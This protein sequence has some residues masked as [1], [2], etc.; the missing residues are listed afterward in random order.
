MKRALLAAGVSLAV[1]LTA[2]A[3]AGDVTV[4]FLDVGQG[5]AI[6]IRSPEGKTALVDAGPTNGIMNLLKKKG[7]ESI[8]LVVVSHHHAD[9]I[10]GMAAVIEK[11][12]PKFYAD[13]NSSHTSTAY[14][15]LL[16]AVDRAGCKLVEPKKDSERKIQLGSVMLRLFPQPGEDKKNENNNSIGIRLDY[17]EFSVLLT[18]DS[19]QVERAW[20]LEHAEESL[21]RHVTIMKAAHHGSRNGADEGW[22]KAT[23][24][25]LVVVSCGE[26]NSYGH[27]HINTLNLLQRLEVPVK[28]TDV[29]G[30]ITIESDGKT[31]KVHVSH[32]GE[33]KGKEK[34][35]SEAVRPTMNT[36]LPSAVDSISVGYVASKNSQVFHKA[37]C[38]SAAK[39]LAK[40]LVQYNSR[41]EAVQAGKKPCAECGP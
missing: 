11:Y 2:T 40:N 25:K 19:E 32:L 9:H 6:L 20:W 5:D 12:K 7:V 31:W 41:D 22:L 13:S 14:Q 29:D 28:R 35:G 30:T 34:G 27:P 10:N 18:G 8:D 21:Y 33:H 16:E 36:K 15:R 39:I 38:K 23:R 24:P 1:V 3:R 17:D 4:S 37:G 26:G